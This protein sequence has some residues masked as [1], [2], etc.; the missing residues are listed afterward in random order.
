[1]PLSGIK[2]GQLKFFTKSQIYNLHITS[3]NILEQIG[4]VMDDDAA[5]KLMGD[6]G[7]EVNYK[8]RIVKIPQ[9]LVLEALGKIPRNITLY[10]RN[11]RNDVTLTRDMLYNGSANNAIAVLDFNG[12]R[13]PAKFK[14][15]EDFTR[16]Q[17]A[18][19]NIHIMST[20][21]TAF[22]DVPPKG[23]YKKCY[24]GV[25]RNTEKHV[26]NQADGA[27]EV[28]D[29]ARMAAAV[30]DAELEEVGKK[31]IFSVIADLAPPLKYPKTIVEIIMECAKYRIPILLE[32]DPYAGGTAP[33]TTAGILLQQNAEILA[34][35]T[36][37][38]LTK[39]GTPIIYTCAPMILDMRLG[40]ASLGAPERGV[41]HVAA[42]QLCRYYGI[43]LCG[44]AGT[45]DSKIVDVQAGYEKAISYLMAALSGVNII[46]SHTGTLESV[47]TISY[48]QSVIDDE[49]YGMV[50]RI[51]RGG[52]ISDE[53]L[54]EA[55]EVI[56]KVGPLGSHYLSQEHTRRYFSLEE[57]LPKVSDRNKWD[58][59]VK[60][61][62]KSAL[63][64]AREKAEKIL[65]EHRPEP[66]PRDTLE[67]I[68]RI[69]EEPMS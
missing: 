39:P 49:I 31:P 15:L 44:V 66:L 5:L 48:E 20:P 42:A 58:A 25:V 23:V 59:W 18:L 3:L 57:W 34:G 50:F 40:V 61:G 6:S 17:D 56:G 53:S 64:L 67:E 21:I 55:F 8:D 4:V 36:L 46:T 60:K 63:K 30:M 22:S 52:D 9:H 29:E 45:T 7:A 12:E 54:H 32:S 41:Y 62:M 19:E 65:K 47:L 24:E 10:G 69:A 35:I 33:I 68:T 26:I 37:A 11:S 13:R 27:K 43:P 28:R 14:D 2:G 38:E 16:L 1:M 51:L